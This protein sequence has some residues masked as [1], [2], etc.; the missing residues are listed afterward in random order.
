MSEPVPAAVADQASTYLGDLQ[1]LLKAQ[2]LHTRILTQPE[3]L[4]RLRVINPG[5]AS[6]CEV[7]MAAPVEGEWSF[8]WSW[9][10]PITPVRDAAIAARRIGHVLTPAA[11]QFA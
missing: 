1:T 7:I 3:R 2:G 6:L 8:W 5:C 11:H 10:E 9:A 4:P